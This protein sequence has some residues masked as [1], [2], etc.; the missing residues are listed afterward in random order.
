MV[1]YST[2]Q[3][4][5]M[6]LRYL[7]ELAE[8]RALFPNLAPLARHLLPLVKRARRRRAVHRLAELA[9]GVREAHRRALRLSGAL[10]LSRLTRSTPAP[11]LPVLH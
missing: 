8:V 3:L 1:M 10:L 9:A 11:A 7:R 2:L 5:R 4:P 6:P